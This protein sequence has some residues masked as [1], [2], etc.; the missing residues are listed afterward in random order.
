MHVSLPQPPRAMI[1][2]AGRGVRLRPLTDH[3]PKPL[4]EAGGRPLIE[5][6]LQALRAAGVREVVINLGWL[7]ERIEA[8][9]GEG[10][11]FGL[12]IRYAREGWPALETGGGIFHALP[13]LGEV[14]FLVIN[15]DVYS[16]CPLGDLVERAR[17][18]AAHDLAHLV[19]VD[20][21]DWHPAGDFALA[22]TRVRVDG[23]PRLTFSGY[24]VQRPA[25]YAG[26]APGA[27]PLLPRLQ[28][29]IAAGRL[30]G[31]R[32]R[33]YWCDAGN[34]ERLDELRR[35]IAML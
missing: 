21:P 11:R 22:G 10:A 5:H 9:L 12:S 2:A 18:L 14:P 6:H 15:G 34:P 8:A 20:S 7:G 23:Q 1:L 28:A 4:I 33:G 31:E 3:C 26:C 19:L 16:D 35:H 30:A 29:A 32:Y 25:L 17:T 27:F 24:S 13:L